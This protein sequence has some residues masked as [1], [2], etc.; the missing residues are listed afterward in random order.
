MSVIEKTKQ[1]LAVA[2]RVG[3]Q[4]VIAIEAT[5]F[6]HVPASI[7]LLDVNELTGFDCQVTAHTVNTREVSTVIEGVKVFV[8]LE[9]NESVAS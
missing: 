8:V 2:K 4:S 1:A 3:F 9:I 7:H 5:Q 6:E